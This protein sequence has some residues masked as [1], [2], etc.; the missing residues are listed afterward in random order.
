MGS[1]LPIG[2]SDCR[3]GY[4][5]KTNLRINFYIF[6]Y[7]REVSTFWELGALLFSLWGN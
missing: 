4:Q 7:S 1:H 3:L 6:T 5:Y 2:T